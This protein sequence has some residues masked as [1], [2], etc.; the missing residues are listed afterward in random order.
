MRGARPGIDQLLNALLVAGG[1]SGGVSA[2]QLMPRW[3]SSRVCPE[4]VE[5]SVIAVDDPLPV[6]N[7][8][9]DH[10]CVKQPP[11]PLLRDFVPLHKTV[12][13]G[14]ILDDSGRPFGNA[15]TVPTTPA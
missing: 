6:R 2:I 11:E 14:N 8:Q 1:V 3:K 5:K 4:H 15:P 10:V 9:S 13:F 12:P 7:R